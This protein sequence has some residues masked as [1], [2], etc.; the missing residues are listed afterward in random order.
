MACLHRSIF[1]E[2]NSLKSATD[3]FWPAHDGASTSNHGLCSMNG[4]RSLRC[5]VI[6]QPFELRSK[7]HRSC[8]CLNRNHNCDDHFFISL[9]VK[10][11]RQNVRTDGKNVRALAQTV[12][13]LV[14][15]VRA[16][17]QTVRALVKNVKPIFKTVEY[18]STVR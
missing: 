14:K 8:D 15:S 17:A 16:L 18:P 4:N 3:L 13:A 11:L 12:G 2:K 7:T 6:N 9:S 5:C 10:A 1:K